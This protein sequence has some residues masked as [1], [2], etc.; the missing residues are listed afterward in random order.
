MSIILGEWYAEDDHFNSI[1]HVGNRLDSLEIYQGGPP[2]DY[3]SCSAADDTLCV[4][5]SGISPDLPTEAR[6]AWTEY[7]NVN[8]KNS[9]G[10]PA[11]P[12][13]VHSK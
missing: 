4:F 2:V 6:L 5:G 9:A 3:D 7:H 8:L 11:R 12:A 13:I 1:N 10:I